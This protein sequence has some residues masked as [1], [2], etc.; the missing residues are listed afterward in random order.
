MKENVDYEKIETS[1]TKKEKVIKFSEIINV[2]TDFHMS[3]GC[4]GRNKLRS[5]FKERNYYNNE[6]N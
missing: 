1:F 3:N 5:L 4:A 6:S 2:I